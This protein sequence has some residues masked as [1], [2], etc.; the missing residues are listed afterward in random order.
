MAGPLG[1]RILFLFVDLALRVRL[2]ERMAL[3]A[4][5]AGEWSSEFFSA[6]QRCQHLLSR[7]RNPFDR[8][9]SLVTRHSPL[10]TRHSPLATRHSPLA[11][12]H[13]PLATRHSPLV[14]RHSSRAAAS[15]VAAWLRSRVRQAGRTEI[16]DCTHSK[17]GGESKMSSTGFC[18]TILQSAASSSASKPRRNVRIQEPHQNASHQRQSPRD[19]A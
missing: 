11:T 13:S 19:S 18:I 1:M 15:L 12:R 14:T 5:N 9:S 2:L 8:H 16:G 3:W 7:E 4:G 6:R 17:P 10:V